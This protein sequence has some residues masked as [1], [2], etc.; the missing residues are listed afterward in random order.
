MKHSF[1][2][3]VAIIGLSAGTQAALA[4][5]ETYTLHGSACSMPASGSY[6]VSEVGVSNN[7]PAGNMTYVCPFPT[8]GTNRASDVTL[9]V[10]G[11]DRNNNAD[12]GCTL[13]VT[14]YYGGIVAKGENHLT[15]AATLEKQ[16]FKITLNNLANPDSEKLFY[17]TCGVPTTTAMGPSY[18]SSLVLTIT[19]LD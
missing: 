18:L 8:H 13:T 4:G 19:T 15:T 2:S 3:L 12:L 5:T 7:G 14:D 1:L 17:V 11:F 6:P 9:R 10:R 16:T